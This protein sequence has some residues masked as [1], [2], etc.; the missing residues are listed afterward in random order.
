M[1]EIVAMIVIMIIIFLLL[2]WLKKTLFLF[3]FFFKLAMLFM[4]IVVVGS[5]VFG[6]LVV[7]DANDFKNNFSNST[8]MMIVKQTTNGTESFLAGVT[9]NPEK[10]EYN[11]MSQK[12]LSNVEQL[13]KDNKISTLGA[14]YYKVFIIELKSFDEVKLYNISDQNVELSGAEIK[15]IMLSD[16]ARADLSSIIAKKSGRK[17]NDVYNELAATDEGVKSYLLSYYLST[18]FNPS[19]ITQFLTQLKKDN[20]QVYANTPLFQAIKL[21]PQTLI[22]TM[23]PKSIT[24]T[25]ISN[26][27]S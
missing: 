24:N 4:L 23:A 14:D 26:V 7:K 9:L 27:T 25:S 8:S 21:V 22:N 1:I 17:A 13:Y 11:S 10:K 18:V 3:G 19:N 12:Q 15:T 5:F 2:F 20:I 6:Y 16:N